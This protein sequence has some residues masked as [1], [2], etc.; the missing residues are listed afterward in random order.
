M[1]FDQMKT[2]TFR[3]KDLVAPIIIVILLSLA[4]G[5]IVFYIWTLLILF[6]FIY[7]V[8]VCKG[9]CNSVKHNC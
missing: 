4:M 2:S 5:L 6:V 9:L 8:F 3:K 7:L 1:K